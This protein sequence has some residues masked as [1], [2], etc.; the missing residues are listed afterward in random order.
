MI[1]IGIDPD[2]RHTGIAVVQKFSGGLQ[3][4]RVL[5]ASVRGR[6]AKDRRAG[7]AYEINRAM[8]EILNACPYPPKALTVEWQRLRPKGEKNP[9]AIVDLTG[10]SGMCLAMGASVFPEIPYLFSPIPS[11]WKGTVPKDIHQNRILGRFHLDSDLRYQDGYGDGHAPGAKFL[12][13]GHRSHV[14]DALGIAGWTL[15]EYGPVYDAQVKE[16]AARHR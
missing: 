5:T 16:K 15:S 8:Q 12:K 7:M 2:T 9:N 10:I 14:I 13:K 6:T 4:I 11:E 1:A 3:I